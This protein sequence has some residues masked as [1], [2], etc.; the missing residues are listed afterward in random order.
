MKRLI[1]L[2]TLF[3]LPA[4]GQLNDRERQDLPGVN[5]VPNA[6]FENGLS[7]WTFTG[8]ST[9][10]QATSGTNLA[11]GKGSGVW[12]ASAATETLTSNPVAAPEIFKNKLCGAWIWY[13]GGDANIDLQAISG[14]STVEATATLHAT[15]EFVQ[16]G[17]SFP[18]PSP[19][20]TLA[21]RLLANADAAAIA[22][23]KT[24][25]GWGT[26]ST[27][28]VVTDWQSYTPAGDPG[29][30][31]T[32]SLQAARYRQ[33][34]SS[35]D[36]DLEYD[37]TGGSESGTMSFADTDWLP[38][39]FTV[40]TSLIDNSSVTGSWYASDNSA[41]AGSDEAAGVC[42]VNNSGDIQCFGATLSDDR[43][44]TGYPMSWAANDTLK[45]SI[46]SVPIAELQ[47]KGVVNLIKEENVTDWKSCT[48]SVD[49]TTET[50]LECFQKRVGSD[51]H[52]RVGFV[53]DTPGTG[54]INIE[55]PG[56]LNIETSLV[57]S[58]EGSRN[59][60]NSGRWFDAS[61]SS[62]S[63]LAFMVA[64]GSTTKIRMAV[65]DGSTTGVLDGADLGNND[66]IGLYVVL[67]ITEW[68]NQPSPLVGFSTVQPNAAGLVPQLD[69]TCDAAKRVCSTEYTPVDSVNSANIVAVT[70]IRTWCTLIYPIVQCH[71]RMDVDCSD[72][73]TWSLRIDLPIDPGA[74]F[75]SAN[76]LHGLL[77]SKDA[78]Q[79]G[80]ISAVSGTKLANV[81]GGSCT[82]SPDAY[83]FSFGYEIDF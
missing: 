23:D 5:I 70:P 44:G 18:C 15:T 74:N 53:V 7:K 19:G 40:D 8:S 68:Q 10:T 50:N 29:F 33:V 4:F 17:V 24:G 63:S 57:P 77:A 35:Y 1:F 83:T 11:L 14:G 6:G 28:A 76:D 54:D 58:A 73:L 20:T 21:I 26:M 43:L 45:I 31:I 12:D 81:I 52:L 47:G 41:A 51:M 65:T 39:G 3:S 13:N 72:T 56:G 69:G 66:N 79:P 61:D 38:S 36:V 46:R 27:G 16:A 32:W 48:T 30:G 67:P 9:L 55:V 75:A 22:I 25:I 34:G 37:A 82:T 78:A 71:G 80:R 42:R 2:L 49:N 64:T 60:L 59:M 62:R